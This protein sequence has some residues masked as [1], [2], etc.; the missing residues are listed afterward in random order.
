MKNLSINA[1]LQIASFV[2]IIVVSCMIATSSIYSVTKLS[3]E[4]IKKFSEDAYEKKEAELKNY[5]SLAVK[6]VETYY[7]R[8]SKEKVKDEVKGELK[9]QTNFI[10]SIIEGE[11][12]KYSSSVPAEELKERI[13]QI[14]KSTRYGDNGYFWI[15]D[16]DAV[17]VMHPIKPQLDGKNLYEY[18][19]KGGKQ[20]FKEFASVA[21]KNGDGFVDYVWPKPG[22]EQPQDKVSYVKLF[23]PYNWVIGTGEYVDNV[24]DKMKEE[25]LKTISEMRYGKSGYY[26]INDSNPKMVMH[27]IKP[28]LNGKDLS[29]VKDPSGKFLFNE[30]VKATSTTDGGFVKYMWAKPGK[31]NPQPKLSYV[32]KFAA[33][34]WIIGTGEYVDNIEEEIIAMKKATKEEINT[35]VMTIIILT[36]IVIVLTYVIS[37]ILF[38]RAIIRPLNDLDEVIKEL[39]TSKDNKRKEI[40]KQANDEIGNVVDSF[41][42]Y[43]AKLDDIAKQDEVVIAEVEDVIQKVNNGFYV[44]KVHSNSDN[45]LVQKLK[46]SINSMIDQT[47]IRLKEINNTLLDYGNAD[48]TV[49]NNNSADTIS[50]G[51][52]GSIINSTYLLGSSV[53]ELIAM[54]TNS[55][56]KLNEDTNILS[57]EV[58]K[59]A[60][61]ANEQAASLEETAAAVEE[62][63]SIIKVNV[64]KIARMSI[65]ANDLNTSASNGQNLANKTTKAMEDID[66]QVNSINDAIT[67]IDQIA[68]QTNILSLNAAVEAAT[69]GEAGK[70]FAV[71]AQEVRNLASRSA[72]AAKEI[73]GIVEA[74]TAKANEGKAIANDM[75]SG[76]NELNSK[77][78]ET[79]S[80]ISDV[81][82][83]SKE[84]ESGI[85]Q[86][87]DAIT[88]LDRATQINASS[89][90]QINTLSD[91]VLDLSKTLLSI[92]DRTKYDKSKEA[93][94]CDIDLV[95][96]ISKLKND[97]IVFKNK[98]F[99]EVG[100]QNLTSWSV[101]KDTECD[102]G[103]WIL[104]QEKNGE[105]Y[106]KTSA[107][108]ELKSHHSSV[109]KEVQ[110]YVDAN[111]NKASNQELINISK[112]I[113]LSTRSVFKNLDAIKVDCC[114][115]GIKSKVVEPKIIDT[116]VEEI[117]APIKNEYEYKKVESKVQT[118]EVATPKAQIITPTNSDDDEWES[119]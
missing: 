74:A 53:S 48:F 71:V 23:E 27:P 115:L 61:S 4:T 76:Y 100:G 84:Q 47:Y 13:R 32:Q 86:I 50:N 78:S 119:F 70:G 57:T 35:I 99:S 75:S 19:D 91:E 39:V 107:W 118:K 67:V 117:K 17:I 111:V 38:N 8:T 60:K 54:I 5:V 103:K 62:I 104:E 10:M 7:E 31:E 12:N 82:T 9:K 52:V 25:A 45:P 21:K 26:W 40:K 66:T 63:T 22:F 36:L 102:L 73:K 96:K 101:T 105:S 95:Y 18:K 109:H 30:M 106:T 83:G 46:D 65:L 6:T 16:T 2:S 33:W 15:N 3:D 44:Y 79:I 89:A 90:S 1:K 29:K 112:N 88:S 87:N 37:T 68:F 51:I 77:V 55:G 108:S 114:K 28:S 34:D 20:I 49:K 94:I 110:A 64:E 85:I 42:A 24:T 56:K 59:L 93:Q 14:V 69:A 11:Y 72:E 113:E 97:H 41:N 81:S 58:D 98:N 43:I 116:K 92:A 80:L